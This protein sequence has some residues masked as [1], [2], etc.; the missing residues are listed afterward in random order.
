LLI[1]R[2]SGNTLAG[3]AAHSSGIEAEWFAEL[4]P[5][6][7]QYHVQIALSDK[8]GTLFWGHSPRQTDQKITR[9]EGPW[10]IEAFNTNGKSSFGYSR[11]LVLAG[12][13]VLIT[14][15]ITVAWFIGHAVSRELSVARLQS[16]FV[17]AVSHEF[18]TPLTTLCQLSE[19]LQRG[20]V[21]TESDR[22]QFY[23]LLHNES[24]R[25]RRLV[26][27][28]LNFGRLETG[29]LQFRFEELD[30]AA[31]VKQCTDDFGREQRARGY[32]FE[33]MADSDGSKI[34]AD[35][36]TLQCVFGNLLENAVK[37][38]PDCNTVW[39]T[40]TRHNGSVEVAVRDRGIGIPRREQ[41]R[42]F[43]KFMRGAAARSS[44]VR[45]TGIG[46]AMAHQIVRAHGG[47]I[48]VESE[49][50]AGSTFRVTFPVVPQ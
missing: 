31:L 20:R 15:I 41:Q 10:T 27:S 2:T 35:R 39:I 5:K 32:R 48:A 7:D 46:L 37:Y 34:R 30:P 22:L 26:E 17:S 1:W 44:D 6:L 12:V 49:P 19:L 36:E 45:G 3:F 24:T 29:T 9:V 25:L 18:R 4:Q 13:V 21:S 11:T 50:G 40:L 28:L 38:S 16:D 43:E 14:L 8:E 47:D 42:I 23:A 33:V